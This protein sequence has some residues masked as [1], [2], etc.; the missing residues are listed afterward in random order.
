MPRHF[1]VVSS[2]TLTSAN[3]HR[4]QFLAITANLI[5]E[6]AWDCIVLA[7]DAQIIWCTTLAV[8]TIA[9]FIFLAASARP[10][11][12]RGIFSAAPLGSPDKCKAPG[13]A[14]DAWRCKKDGEKK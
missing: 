11:M 7:T 2:A 1:P 13:D 8:I 10:F 9:L 14:H 4:R 3:G 12:W 6:V 5:G